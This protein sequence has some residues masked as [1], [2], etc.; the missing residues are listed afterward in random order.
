MED[1]KKRKL[2]MKVQ[3][4]KFAVVLALYIAFLVWVKSW[5]GVVVIPIRDETY[6]TKKVKWQLWKEA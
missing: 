5:L 2:N 4:A 3:W 1:L 6:I